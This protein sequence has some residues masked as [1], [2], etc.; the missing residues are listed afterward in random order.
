MKDTHLLRSLCQ[1]GTLALAIAALPTPSCAAPASATL[2]LT[3][4]RD[5]PLP[6]QATRWDYMAYDPQQQ[7]LAIA[8][9]GD[10]AAVIVDARTGDVIGTI[11]DLR[12][13]HGVL[14]VPETGRLYATATGTNQLAVIDARTLQVI[15]RV[16]TG[17]YPDGLAYAPDV[18]KI[19]VSDAHGNSE[20]V[21]DARTNQRVATIP[22]GGSVGNTQYDGVTRHIFV[23]VQGTN[24]LV[25]IDP[26]SD[27]IVQRIPLP[28]S[29]GNH[30]LLIDAQH[31]LAFI[32]CEGNDTLLVLNLKTQTVASRFRVA[33]GPD[34]LAFDNAS[35]LLYVASEG[36]TVYI[37]Q[38]DERGVS[39]AG[40]AAIGMN[41]HTL[42]VD[43][44]SHQVY[45]P[46]NLP[47]GKP[48][49]RVLRPTGRCGA[50]IESAELDH[51]ARTPHPGL[52]DGLVI[53][54]HRQPLSTCP[55][56]CPL[57]T[58]AKRESNSELLSG[59]LY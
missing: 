59:N 9:L 29:D 38:V 30:G 53:A 55:Q 58:K 35:G 18:Q 56:T 37:F 10:S 46:V 2:T 43:P 11:K 22:L 50:A 23:N 52:H 39:A 4:V 15:A 24:E 14:S 41:A 19:Y 26:S 48:V 8:H 1:A 6:G 51:E 34:V 49:L 47:N 33:G 57:G 7:R 25:E 12:Q 16:P 40:K 54:G 45:L 27:R 13:V 3:L 28:G 31:R 36:G 21:I 17:R 20:T 5:Y 32:A 44:T 42:A